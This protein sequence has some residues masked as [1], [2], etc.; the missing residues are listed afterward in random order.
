MTLPVQS[1]LMNI[2]RLARMV[3]WRTRRRSA[4]TSG[5]RG[6]HIARDGDG[7]VEDLLQVVGEAL[8]DEAVRCVLADRVRSDLLRL[9]PAKLMRFFV[10]PGPAKSPS[11]TAKAQGNGIHQR[12]QPP[13]RDVRLSRDLCRAARSGVQRRTILDKT[14]A[15]YCTD[16]KSGNWWL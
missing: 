1:V 10:Y 11:Y 2:T 12:K 16:L 9:F 5:S 3:G 13:G 7:T 6:D 15:S 4:V 8:N 14:Q